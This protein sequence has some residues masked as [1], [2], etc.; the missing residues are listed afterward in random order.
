MVIDHGRLVYDG[1]LAGL[2]EAGESERTLVVDLER[3]LPPIEAARGAGG[4]GG[5]AAAVAG[6]PGGGVGG[7]AGGA[8][9]G[10][11]TRWWTCRCG[12]RTSRR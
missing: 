5:G 9:R 10:A 7:A 11:G 8:Y 4:A 1:A 12:S 3:E 2:H 6:V